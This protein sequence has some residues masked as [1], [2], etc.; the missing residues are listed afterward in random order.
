MA[1]LCLG[2]LLH[3][4]LYSKNSISDPGYLVGYE[5]VYAVVL[6]GVF[7]AFYLRKR[8]GAAK[9][10][11]FLAIYAAL[12]A[13]ALTADTKYR[14]QAETAKASVQRDFRQ[15]TAAS[16]DA[17]GNPVPVELAAAVIPEA[18][19]ESGQMELLVRDYM[20]QLMAA[21]NS[22]IRSLDSIGWDHILDAQRIEHDQNLAESR[23]MIAGAEQS[24]DSYENQL[25]HLMQLS[26]VRIGE[27]EMPEDAK[28]A[29][30]EGFDQGSAKSA[31]TITKG[32]GLEREVLH[33][34]SAIFR[35]LASSSRWTVRDG[36]ILFYDAADLARF[37][38]AVER[39]RAATEQED[40]LRAASDSAMQRA[41]QDW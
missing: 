7:H 38:Q 3:G 17:Q 31:E 16:T 40:A 23:A 9:G 5:L 22:Y 14:A 8:P 4:A 18:S 1:L 33:Q 25:K 39:I 35:Q 26:R 13:G 41:M 30:L 10:S 32:M 36:R 11:A 24:I 29:V 6:W 12:L 27:L 28:R 20:R 19:G 2:I 37:N 15:L 34:V 21:R